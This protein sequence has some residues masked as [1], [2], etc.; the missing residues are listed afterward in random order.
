[1]N[2]HNYAEPLTKDKAVFAF[3]PG[4]THGPMAQFLEKKATSP[5]KPNQMAP[6]GRTRAG[7]DF[8]AADMLAAQGSPPGGNPFEMRR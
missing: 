4:G 2:D 3:N 7:G 1:M 5:P 6:R 8:F